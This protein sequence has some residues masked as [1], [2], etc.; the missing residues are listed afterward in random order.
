MF[1]IDSTTN[2]LI[3]VESCLVEQFRL[4]SVYNR[5]CDV[6]SPASSAMKLL[7]LSVRDFLFEPD[8]ETYEQQKIDI[9]E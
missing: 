1:N 6:I 2:K 9:L 5:D 4:W 3:D 7:L 8:K